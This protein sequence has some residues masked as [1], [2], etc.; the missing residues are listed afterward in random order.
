MAKKAATKGKKGLG[1]LKAA[2][3]GEMMPG[4]KHMMPG[5]PMKGKGKSHKMAQT[6]RKR[7]K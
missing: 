7:G 4:G 3:M 6:G 5:M 1:N 2:V